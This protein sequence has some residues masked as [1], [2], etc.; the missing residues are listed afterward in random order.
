MSDIVIRHAEPRDAE[1]L[2]QMTAHPEVYHNTLQVPHPSDGN[3]ARALQPGVKQLVACIDE[4]VVGH[5]SI[6]VVQRPRR[7]HVADFGVSVDSRWHNRGVASALM[8][9]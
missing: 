9:R 8:R 6:A 4:Q 1:P 5:L 7:S 2:R 3:V